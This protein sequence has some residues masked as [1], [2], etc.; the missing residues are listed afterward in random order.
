MYKN[1]FNMNMHTG[2]SLSYPGL[3]LKANLYIRGQDM[4]NYTLTLSDITLKN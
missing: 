1:S 4:P 2:L 3:R